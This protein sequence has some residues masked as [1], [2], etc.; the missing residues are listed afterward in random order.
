MFLRMILQIY[1]NQHNSPEYMAEVT[2]KM[3]SFNGETTPAES[4]SVDY[5]EII[6]YL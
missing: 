4:Q 1:I 2:T 3:H 6:I 5:T